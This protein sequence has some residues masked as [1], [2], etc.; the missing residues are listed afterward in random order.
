[1]LAIARNVISDSLLVSIFKASGLC[2]IWKKQ[3]T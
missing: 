2:F 1:M 3:I